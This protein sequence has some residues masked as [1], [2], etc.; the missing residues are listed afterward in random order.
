M[1]LWLTVKDIKLKSK[2]SVSLSQVRPLIFW[3]KYKTPKLSLSVQLNISGF[4]KPFHEKLSLWNNSMYRLSFIESAKRIMIWVIWVSLQRAFHIR[5]RYWRKKLQNCECVCVHA[6]THAC[7]HT[8]EVLIDSDL[9]WM[10][11]KF[12]ERERWR[13]EDVM[14]G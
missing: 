10:A 3:H 9:H 8:S 6:H 14:R 2:C 12:V 1:K 7:V 5:P 11:E 13:V 4:V